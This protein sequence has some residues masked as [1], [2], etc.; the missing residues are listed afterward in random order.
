MRSDT[1][2][3]ATKRETWQDIGFSGHAQEY[4]C[5]VLARLDALESLQNT[6]P[7]LGFG[8]GFVVT[9]SDGKMDDSSMSLVTNLMLSLAVSE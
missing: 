4:A 5:L 9:I 7:H 3:E 1:I 6:G 2:D 8:T